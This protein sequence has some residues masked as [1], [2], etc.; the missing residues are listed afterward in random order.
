MVV[1]LG[2]PRLQRDGSPISVGRF[3]ELSGLLQG[4]PEVAMDGG[5]AGFDRGR[6]VQQFGGLS[7]PSHSAEGRGKVPQQIRGV[8]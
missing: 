6:L 4:D 7:V 8:R 3:R 5:A 1:R 2:V